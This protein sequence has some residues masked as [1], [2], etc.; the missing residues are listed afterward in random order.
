MVEPQSICSGAVTWARWD[1]ATFDLPSE[2]NDT[3]YSV[4]LRG[5]CHNSMGEQKQFELYTAVPSEQIQSTD[6]VEMN[7][8]MD[9]LNFTVAFDTT[10]LLHKIESNDDLTF[11]SSPLALQVL[12]N[13]Q[14]NATWTWE[15]E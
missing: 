2:I 9:T 7:D 5:S 6:L 3:T 13:I 4:F 8:D 12:Y 11:N 14:N 1:G 15:W 10:D